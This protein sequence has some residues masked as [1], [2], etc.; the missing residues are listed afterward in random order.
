MVSGGNFKTSCPALIGTLLHPWAVRRPLYPRFIRCRF[1]W[2]RQRCSYC[3]PRK[4]QKTYF[5]CPVYLRKMFITSLNASV[6]GIWWGL[7]STPFLLLSPEVSLGIIQQSLSSSYQSHSRRHKAPTLRNVIRSVLTA[8]SVMIPPLHLFSLT[9]WRNF[10]TSFQVIVGLC[11]GLCFLI[12]PLCLIAGFCALLK[13]QKALSYSYKL[14]RSTNFND[15]D[16]WWI[17]V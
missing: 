9:T 15:M 10:G 12:S 16:Y 8:R 6:I 17:N 5:W 3:F 4:L 7:S 1:G 13:F 11:L 2:S 14:G